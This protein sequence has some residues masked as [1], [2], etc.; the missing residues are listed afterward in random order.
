MKEEKTFK[1]HKIVFFSIP[2]WVKTVSK[3]YGQQIW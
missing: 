1:D 3:T 2:N